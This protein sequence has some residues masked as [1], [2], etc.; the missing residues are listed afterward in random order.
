MLKACHRCGRIHDANLNCTKK[1]YTTTE[2]RKLRS[3]YVWHLKREEIKEK[4]NYLCEV[5]KRRGILTY[6]DLEV[7]HIEKLRDNKDGFLD[8]LN[9]ICLCKEHHREAESGLISIDELKEIAEGR[10][11]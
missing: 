10:E 5:C 4:A 3:K 6:K 8:N 9:L 11:R 2:E 1:V 7:H